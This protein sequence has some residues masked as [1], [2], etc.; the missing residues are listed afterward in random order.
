MNSNFIILALICIVN[1]DSENALVEKL[2]ENNASGINILLGHGMK[3]PSLLDFSEN[4]KS[5]IISFIRAENEN[6]MLQMLKDYNFV[7]NERGIAFTMN[8]DA[9]AGGK[10]IFYLQDK[11]REYIEETKTEK[12]KTE[13][14]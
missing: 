10:T 9:A 5:V 3:K 7:G 12:E 4:H 14:K 6:N 8:V 11:L 1:P 2:Y 13:L